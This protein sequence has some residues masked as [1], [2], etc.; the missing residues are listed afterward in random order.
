MPADGMDVVNISFDSP[1]VPYLDR[2]L[3]ATSI[4]RATRL[5]MIVVVSAGVADDAEY[6]RGGVRA[7]D[8]CGA[9]PAP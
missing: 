3:M 2:N 9:A 5:G 1:L 4:E 7:T 6:R 8:R